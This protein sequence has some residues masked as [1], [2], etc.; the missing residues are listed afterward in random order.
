MFYSYLWI[1]SEFKA[2]ADNL[3]RPCFKM[4]GK[5]RVGD[6]DEGGVE[7]LPSMSKVPGSSHNTL[8]FF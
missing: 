8:R 3:V 2:N 7:C 6:V 1:Q 4:K 5:I